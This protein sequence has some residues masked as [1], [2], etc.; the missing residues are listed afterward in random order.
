MRKPTLEL[1]LYTGASAAAL[2]IDAGLLTLLVGHLGWPYLAAAATSFVT[3]GVFLYVLSVNFVFRFRRIDNPV[4]ELP[5]F[6]ALGL[7]GLSVNIVVM[8]AAVE[9]LHAHYLVA[10]AMA[11]GCT[12]TVNFLLRRNLMFSR[13]AQSS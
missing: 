5:L 10:K 13:L 4:V 1:L 7:V 6:V 12:F 11:A 2:L 8:F 9:T 3:G